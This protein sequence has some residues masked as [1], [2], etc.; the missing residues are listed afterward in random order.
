MHMHWR[1]RTAPPPNI[2]SI[3]LHDNKLQDVEPTSLQ[4]ATNY[5]SLCS[6]S[7]VVW[8]GRSTAL[9]NICNFTY[10]PKQIQPSYFWHSFENVDLDVRRLLGISSGQ[11]FQKQ[12]K[13]FDTSVFSSPIWDIFQGPDIKIQVV[14]IWTPQHLMHAK[15]PVTLENFSQQ[16]QTLPHS[17]VTVQW[18]KA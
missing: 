1:E 16:V 15:S 2:I 5:R 18:Q 17:G 7:A 13:T 10:M 9:L 11:N 4:G 8:A 14:I 12:L 3:L 6:L